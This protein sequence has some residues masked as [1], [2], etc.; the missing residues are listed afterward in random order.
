MGEDNNI[1]FQEKLQKL[2]EIVEK[3]E[4]KNI[5]LEEALDLFKGGCL[6][7]KELKKS[8]K[9]AKQKVE[10]YSKQILQEIEEME[11]EDESQ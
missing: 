9:E 7:L 10:I 1:T 6:L 11:A 3:L 5:S 4:D 8:L 2:K